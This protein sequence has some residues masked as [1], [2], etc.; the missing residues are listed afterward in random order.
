MTITKFR[1]LNKENASPLPINSIVFTEKCHKKALERNDKATPL[2]TEPLCI[3]RKISD[4]EYSLITGYRD[5]MTAKNSGSNTVKAIVVPDQSRSAF[6]DSLKNTFELWNTANIHEPSGW[7]K[8][9]PRPEKVNTCM[10]HYRNTGT[11]GKQII[12]SPKGTIL[13]GYAAVCA[14]RRLG[15]E[16]IP[17]Y[18]RKRIETNNSKNRKK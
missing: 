13:D 4:T 10:E 7:K 16:K 2:T 9:S 14:A 11:F 5:Y 3:V 6:M 1:T 18:V 17:V 15:V 8:T 12:V